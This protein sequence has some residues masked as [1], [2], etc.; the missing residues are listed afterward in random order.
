MQTLR[1][2]YSL[3]FYLENKVNGTLN[4]FTFFILVQCKTCI[5]TALSY[6]ENL[7]TMS[8]RNILECCVSSEKPT[9]CNKTKLEMVIVSS[10][11]LLVA[12]DW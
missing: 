4:A 1:K 9:T 7:K 10:L 5:S 6:W 2:C 3:V 11:W 12:S 8:T